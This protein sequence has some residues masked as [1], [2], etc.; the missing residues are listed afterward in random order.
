[1]GYN[2]ASWPTGG[3]KSDPPVQVG[4]SSPQ[5]S[6]AATPQFLESVQTL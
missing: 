1:V 5:P 3:I 2:E 6:R 4:H